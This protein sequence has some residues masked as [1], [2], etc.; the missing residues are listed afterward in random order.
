VENSGWDPAV[1]KRR[2]AA[3]V[4]ADRGRHGSRLTFDIG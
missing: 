1:E 2:F 4:A 3:F